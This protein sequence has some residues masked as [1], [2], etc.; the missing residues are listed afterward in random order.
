MPAQARRF[1]LGV[2]A[3]ALAIGHARG[4]DV[5]H[6]P[7]PNVD[8]DEAVVALAQHEADPSAIVY[9][10][11]V[12]PAPE[13]SGSAQSA[14]S[15][16]A[17]PGDGLGAEQPGRRSPSFKPD[18]MTDLEGSLEYY[19]AFKP[20]IA[21]FKRVTSLDATVL[22]RDGKTP[23]LTIHDPRRRPVPIETANAKPPDARP[24]D[25][26]FGE[27]TLDFSQGRVVPLPSVSPESRILSLRTEP[28]TQIAIE[29][30]GADNFFA[31]A[32]GA[33]PKSTVF[34]AFLTDAPRAYFGA[35]L[36]HGKVSALAAEVPELD[37]SIRSRALGFAATLGVN[38]DSDLADA[39][40]A[41]VAHFRAFEESSEPPPDTGDIYLDLARAKKGICRHRTYAFVVTA[42]ALGIPA[43]F[44]QN[45]AHSWAEVK[46]PR[47]G[48]M[49]ID[50]GGSAHGLTAHGAQ[51]RPQYQPV[52][53][54]PLPRPAAYERSYSLAG[55]DARGV[56]RPGDKELQGRW[57][58]PSESAAKAAQAKPGEQASFMGARSKSAT[59]TELGTRA[60]LTVTLAER[61]HSVM[62]GT[63]LRVAGRIQNAA[64]LGVAG[65]RIE[66]SLA[67]EGRRE[68]MLLGVAVS[69]ERGAFDAA[70]GVPPD[71]AVGDYRLVVVTPGNAAYL[72]AMA[73]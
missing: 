21:P 20:S 70:F 69:S 56:R 34:V 45:E 15:M 8:P 16:L 25:R 23:V 61:H 17:T 6:E 12:L 52:E 24:R 54:D 28:A 57:V 22:D 33:V 51:D 42:H 50:L 35:E 5:L 55:R 46:L 59:T 65:L 66:V 63:D 62:R 68:R 38:R 72:P 39:L 4:D 71:L 44:V 73:E 31:V 41:L 7:V 18:R 64:G 48:F 10:G 3:A 40:S 60:P 14:P 32:Q 9:D 26:F 58:A 37:P 53:P 67:T 27:V 1:A 30:D 29:R 19:E 2:V 13:R 49:R 11:E 47:I 36:P 43:R